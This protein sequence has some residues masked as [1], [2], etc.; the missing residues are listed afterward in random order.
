M[1]GDG[2]LAEPQLGVAASFEHGQEAPRRQ[3]IAENQLQREARQTQPPEV[4]P[5][6]GGAMFDA[7]RLLQLR[8]V[9]ARYDSGSNV[10]CPEELAC[11]MVEC[12]MPV[13]TQDLV[14]FFEHFDRDHDGRVSFQEF[15]SAFHSPRPN[16]IAAQVTPSTGA[17]GRF[18]DIQFPPNEAAIWATNGAAVGHVQELQAVVGPIKWVRAGQLVSNGRLFNSVHPNDIAH[19]NFGDCSLVSALCALAEFEGAVFA[20]F[21]QK[22]AAPDGCYTM[23][24]FNSKLRQWEAVVV[25]DYIPVS[26]VDGEPI[27]AK[28][29]G[30]DMWVLLA[31]KA[32]AKFFG[33]YVRCAGA[34]VLVP[35]M[36]LTD[37][38]PCRAFGQGRGHGGG[39]PFDTGNYL[40]S[41]VQM[42]NPRD[43]ASL[44]LLPQGQC[45]AEQVW[46]E[47]VASDLQNF[48]MC[49]WTSSKMEAA[50]ES[51]VTADG[52]ARSV[53][54]SV[55]SARE[56]AA[57]GATW[58]CVQLRNPWARL[59]GAEWAGQLSAD[60]RE[61]GLLPELAQELGIGHTGLDGMFW[62]T[63]DDFREHFSDI[64]VVPKAMEVPRLGTVE[65]YAPPKHPQAKHSKSFVRGQA[66]EFHGRVSS[67]C[68][69][70]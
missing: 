4:E 27:M 69:I 18:M 9:F 53:V 50:G 31:E 68:T 40:A 67:P 60:W 5:G 15:M 13:S 65:A 23:R 11:V 64:G 19:G 56:I 62:M 58:R 63:W 37:A 28:P 49:A 70:S 22:R 57:D 41:Q 59:A 54:Y 24:L 2:D 10:L 12:N 38:G 3:S 45:S 6:E 25:D 36:L 52:I 14:K 16:A 20:L 32:I 55:V 17:D 21:E 1:Q 35:Y 51:P 33:S 8:Q 61:W 39:P 43:L 46:Q 26:A 66:S 7:S 42:E 34:H 29:R 44:Q 30:N 47:L 48:I